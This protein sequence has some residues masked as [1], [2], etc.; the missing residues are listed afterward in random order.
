MSRPAPTGHRRART[1]GHIRA[2][3]LRAGPARRRRGG[4]RDPGGRDR[5]AGRR[6]RCEVAPPPGRV[7]EGGRPPADGAQR[8]PRRQHGAP[9]ASTPLAFSRSSSAACSSTWL[10]RWSRPAWRWP[11][12]TAFRPI[13]NGHRRCASSFLSSL[14]SS[15]PEPWCGFSDGSAKEVEQYLSYSGRRNLT[16][17]ESKTPSNAP[18]E[19]G[20]PS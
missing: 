15:S 2:P 14:F 8:G 17:L 7:R 20:G 12:R 18:S 13:A 10:T 16:Y 3:R 1:S 6:R 4:A 5:S 9:K 11:T 19:E